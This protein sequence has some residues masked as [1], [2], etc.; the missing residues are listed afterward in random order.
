MVHLKA[1]ALVSSLNLHY[2]IS[3]HEFAK[4][5]YDNFMVSKT[6]TEPTA[7]AFKLL[8]L[9][10]NCISVTKICHLLHAVGR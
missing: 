10:A 7:T 2:F 6:F 8:S 1:K 4:L 9:A 5:G 3:L